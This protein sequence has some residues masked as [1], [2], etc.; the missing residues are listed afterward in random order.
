VDALGDDVRGVRV[1][2]RV[3]IEPIEACGSCPACVAGRASICP[4]VRLYGIH[5]PGGFAEAICAPAK[6]LFPVPERIPPEIAALAEPMAVALHGVRR[7]GVGAGDRVL[8][9][10][11]GTIGLLSVLTARAAGAGEVWLVARHPHQAELGAAL[12]ATRLLGESEGTPESLASL[13]QE[14]PIDRVVETVGG[15]ADTLRASAAAIRPGGSISVVGVFLG[16][17]AVPAMPMLLKE[18]SLIW[19]NCYEHAEDGSDFADAVS[20]LDAH[21]DLLASVTTASVALDDVGR[22]FQIASDKRAGAVKVTVRP[23]GL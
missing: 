1:G 3:A 6:R 17:V 8:V 19:S 16:D 4:Q 21:R 23:Q 22:G 12:G 10:G 7:G 20:L 14:A 5:A 18:G 15:S 9:L 13:G 11:A 2:D